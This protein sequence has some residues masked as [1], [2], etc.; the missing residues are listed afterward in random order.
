MSRKKYR[1]A[2]HDEYTYVLIC[3]PQETLTV[4]RKL[5]EMFAVGGGGSASL[6]SAFLP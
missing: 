3:C 2:S 4:E 6:V 5:L 1:T